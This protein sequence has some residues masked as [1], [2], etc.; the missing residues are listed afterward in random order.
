MDQTANK[1]DLGNNGLVDL[2]VTE[3]ILNG[4]QSAVGKVTAKFLELGIGER[5][6]EV[7]T[8]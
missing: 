3:H 8:L 4:L 7:H 1:D 6:V 2:Q 5:S